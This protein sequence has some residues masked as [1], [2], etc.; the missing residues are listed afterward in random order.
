[1]RLD[2]ANPNEA[3]IGEGDGASP[4]Q[5]PQCDTVSGA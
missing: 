3:K 2:L 1:M 5:Q 4:Q